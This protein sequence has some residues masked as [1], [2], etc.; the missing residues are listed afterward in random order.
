MMIKSKPGPG[1]TQEQG[2][3]DSPRMKNYQCI[4][5]EVDK[6][7]LCGFLCPIF[8]VMWLNVRGTSPN[9]CA[10]GVTMNEFRQK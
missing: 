8:E 5:L 1:P 3:H 4:K 6:E 10:N 2:H 7:I 9:Q